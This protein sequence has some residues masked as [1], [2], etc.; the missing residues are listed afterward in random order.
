MEM[1]YGG[2][3]CQM[4]GRGLTQNFSSQ[5]NAVQ[6][7]AI[8]ETSNKCNGFILAVSIDEPGQRNHQI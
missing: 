1:E 7:F 4:G 5:N 3:S 8:I 6:I 2:S